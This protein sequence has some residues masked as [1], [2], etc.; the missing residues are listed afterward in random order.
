M[1]T[2][3][4]Q[5]APAADE[6]GLVAFGDVVRLVGIPERELQDLLGIAEVP[7]KLEWIDVFARLD[8]RLLTEVHERLRLERLNTR[9]SR[10]WLS[11]YPEIVAQ[12]HP[13]RNGECFPD[14][15]RYGSRRKAWWKCS[16]GPDHEWEASANK[17]TTGQGCPFCGS[18]RVSVTNSLL[19]RA[20]EV[21]AQWHST[22]NGALTPDKILWSSARKVWWQ[23][24]V[25][26]D[27]EWLAR[28]NGRTS[29]NAAG[30]PFCKGAS[31]APSNALSTLHPELARQWH[32]KRNAPLLPTM[33]KPG[34]P[35]RVW[36]QCPVVADHVWR[37]AI[38]TR[39]TGCGC[40]FCHGLRS[41]YRES[42][43]A[44]SRSLSSEWHPTMNGELRPKDVRFVSMK[45]VFWKCRLDETHVWRSS[46]A[47]RTQKG[48]GC[49]HCAKPR[50]A[51]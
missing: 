33:V 31:A 25:A 7:R 32:M 44:R 2:K 12:W 8:R 50:H 48:R 47:T 51:Q 29:G 42:L 28:I 38:K 24:G 35:L 34:S 9:G 41:S 18:R 30:C 21:A 11:G 23:C 1:P 15:Y 3:R 13:T 14:Q 22:R 43:A 39:A 49:P 40:P 20:P 37:V 4:P 36:W 10:Y 17:R 16:A 45:R 19:N 26:P 5:R 46:I 6:T 27:H